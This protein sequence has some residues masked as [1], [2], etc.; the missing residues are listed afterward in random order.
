MEVKEVGCLWNCW[1]SEAAFVCNQALRHLGSRSWR[2]RDWRPRL[3]S[4]ATLFV[5]CCRLI[6]E[7]ERVGKIWTDE[8]RCQFEAVKMDELI[9]KAESRSIQP[10]FF[11]LFDIILVSSATP[12]GF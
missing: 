1:E 3:K 12:E 2:K 5:L 9:F 11:F 7:N 6:A 4:R 8:K 10:H